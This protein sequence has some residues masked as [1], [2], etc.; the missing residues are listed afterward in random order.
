ML[1]TINLGSYKRTIETDGCVPAKK[2]RVDFTRPNPRPQP[3]GHSV[4]KIYLLDGK[5]YAMDLSGAQFGLCQ[6]VMP[7]D[8]YCKVLG[9]DVSPMDNPEYSV[10]DDQPQDAQ[11]LGKSAAPWLPELTNEHILQV[12][13]LLERN[14]WC[15]VYSTIN[16]W[17]S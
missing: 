16:A 14:V 3:L 12:R 6:T 1:L 2:L 17:V 9:I 11:W 8:V 7:W 15:C 4:F 5:I 10:D 13:H